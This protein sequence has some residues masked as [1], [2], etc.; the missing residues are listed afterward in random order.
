MLEASRE[1]VAEVIAETAVVEKLASENRLGS[2]RF[3]W[4]KFQLIGL[5]VASALGIPVGVA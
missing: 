5:P 4:N 2:W 3:W 1:V